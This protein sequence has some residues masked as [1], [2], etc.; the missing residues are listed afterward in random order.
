M[1]PAREVQSSAAL[2]RILG[3]PTRLAIVCALS[4]GESSVTCLGELAGTTT[5][6]ASQHL[7]K[8]RMSGIVDVRREGTFMIY[9]LSEGEAGR[10]VKEIIQHLPAVAVEHK[11]PAPA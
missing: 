3:D 2:L 1:P 11:L 6:S 5:T 7:A 4:Q 9:S 10:A 8:L